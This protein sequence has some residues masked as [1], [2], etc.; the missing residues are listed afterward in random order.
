ME[1]QLTAD[2]V[3][4]KTFTVGQWFKEYVYKCSENYRRRGGTVA[5]SE[6]FNF[7]LLLKP[8]WIIP[9]TWSQD[10]QEAF[11]ITEDKWEQKKTATFLRD[12]DRHLQLYPQDR[13]QTG[14]YKLH[15]IWETSLSIYIKEQ[16]Y[17]HIDSMSMNSWTCAWRKISSRHPMRM[18]SS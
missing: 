5:E 17:F 9:K 18:R 15:W 14:Q 4:Q 3:R 10:R 6:W 12:V 11:K 1:Q 7:W 13:L 8:E 16:L 2:I